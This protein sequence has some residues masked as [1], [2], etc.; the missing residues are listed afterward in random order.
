MTDH[1]KHLS[2]S[3]K[4]DTAPGRKPAIPREHQLAEKLRAL[5]QENHCTADDVIF[6]ETMLTQI[7]IESTAQAIAKRVVEI[8]LGGKNAP[9]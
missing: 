3:V 1:E 4:V 2:E 5:L 7:R 8:A 6:L 9:G